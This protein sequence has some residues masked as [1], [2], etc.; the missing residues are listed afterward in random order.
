MG[1]GCLLYMCSCGESA[2]RGIASYTELQLHPSV[3]CGRQLPSRGALK[4]NPNSLRTTKQRI[5]RGFQ[6][7]KWHL[8]VLIARLFTPKEIIEEAVDVLADIPELD[9]IWE[10]CVFHINNW[11]E[12][13][14]EEQCDQDEEIVEELS[15]YLEEY[16]G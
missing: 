11:N 3:A 5:H 14:I 1:A 8:T 12:Q 7:A 16:I 9:A 2:S 10:K 4:P 13:S 6:F 15:G